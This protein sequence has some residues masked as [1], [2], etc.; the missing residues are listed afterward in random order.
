MATEAQK[1]DAKILWRPH[2][3]P[4]ENFLSRAEDF[5]LYG[6]AKGGGKTDA[7]L[8]EVLRQ[9]QKPNYKGLL[10][11]RTFPQLQEIIDR[12]H[13]FYPLLGGK[14]EGK[15]GRYV[16]PSGAMVVFG[17]CQHEEDKRRY[18][19]HEY[20]FIGFDQLEEFTES[21]FIFIGMQ[22]RTSDPVLKC[23]IRATANPGGVGHFWIKER[24]IDNYAP[25]R[26]Y[27]KEFPL[28]GGRTVTKTF[29]Y[30]PA[31]VYD[32][33]TLLQAQP[34]Y[35]ATLMEL[36]E[37]ERKAYLEGDWDIFT[38]QCVFD[39]E[40]MRAQKAWIEEP[41][42]VG[43]L[44]D[45]GD[46]IALELHED[47][48]LKIWRPYE[49]K[50][51]YFIAADVAKG[52]EGG[53][54]SSAKVFDRK[55]FS[56]VAKWHGRID[57]AQFGEVLFTLG[58]YYNWAEMAVEV[59]PGPGIATGSKLQEKGYPHLYKRVVPSKNGNQIATEPGWITDERS[60]HQMI[61][62]LQEAIRRKSVIIR[63]KST[64]HEMFNFIRHP[65]GKMKARE[66]CHD[67]Q[68]IDTAMAVYCMKINPV[69][70]LMD[71]GK[72]GELNAPI[73]TS[74]MVNSKSFNPNYRNRWKLK[75]NK[76]EA[77]VK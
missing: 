60:R 13:G 55:N 35:L 51:K 40:G 17:H 66:G 42:W 64:I 52:V 11:R 48:N 34:G 75:K 23:Y 56:L 37:A 74:L 1:E 41:Q 18:Q 30:I 67:D 69:R 6:G 39:Q 15:E 16:F 71:E 65:N 5:V 3:G 31:T 26:T 50:G 8:R 70:E 72:E 10:I 54:Y 19:G 25:G 63:D 22:N 24:F 45:K 20:Q 2:P 59:W 9:I 32:N 62:S 53:D 73:V 77:L 38:T 14:W 33:P 4:Q 58:E 61:T 36:P 57:A 27:E 21:Q 44:R 28:P 68:V 46:N 43:S 12:A 29:C 76:K 49:D 7:L 47:G